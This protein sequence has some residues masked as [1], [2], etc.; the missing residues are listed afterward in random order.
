MDI[1]SVSSTEGAITTIKG[2]AQAGRMVDYVIV[3]EQSDARVEE[4]AKALDTYP[5]LSS[6]K[7]IHLY[8][9]TSETLGRRPAA[10]VESRRPNGK[11]GGRVVR[12]TKPPRRNRMLQMLASLSDIARDTILSP[13]QRESLVALPPPGRS[14]EQLSDRPRIRGNVLIAEGMTG[15]TL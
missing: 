6:T 2:E 15:G 11:S 9:P 5:S 3:D 1:K 14:P 4:I 12:S 7:V 13:S 10:L 8:I